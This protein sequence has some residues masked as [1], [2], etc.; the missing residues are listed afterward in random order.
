MLY[1]GGDKLSE[2]IRYQ[3]PEVDSYGVATVDERYKMMNKSF[4]NGE[5]GECVNYARSMI[6]SALKYVYR[7]LKGVEIGEDLGREY[8]SLHLLSTKTLE[9]LNSELDNEDSIEEIQEEMIK[10]IDIIGKTRNA[11]SVSH[12]SATRTKSVNKIET[13][14]IL[15]NAESIVLMLLDLLFNKTHSLKKNAVGSIIN[16]EGLKKYSDSSYKNEERNINY[17]VLPGTGT[18]SN[19]SVTFPESVNIDKDKEFF[20]EWISEFVEDDVTVED[21]STIGINKFKY[22]SKKKDFYY[23]VQIENNILYITKEFN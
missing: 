15:F 17:M 11:T 2:I 19:I 5:Y 3:R 8:M 18:I 22:Y 21:K 6:E 10:I 14:Y 23:E 9:L 1:I 7:M 13:R 12:G 4:Q 20:S 16:P